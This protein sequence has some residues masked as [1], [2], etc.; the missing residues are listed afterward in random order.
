MITLLDTCATSSGISEE[1]AC[2]FV[3]YFDAEV[4]TGKITADEHPVRGVGKYDEASGMQG[5]GGAVMETR[6]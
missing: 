5:V 1:L 3:S 4:E 2:L 6:F